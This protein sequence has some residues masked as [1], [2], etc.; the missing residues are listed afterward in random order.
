MRTPEQF[1]RV[2]Q[3]AVRFIKFHNKDVWIGP[4]ELIQR[5]RFVVMLLILPV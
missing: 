3:E 4:T 2:H 5:E 1:N